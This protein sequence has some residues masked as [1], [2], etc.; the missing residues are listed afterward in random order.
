MVHLT[1]D[2]SNINPRTPPKMLIPYITGIVVQI[3]LKALACIHV[4]F[5]GLGK[6]FVVQSADGQSGS[7]QKS[8]PTE[9]RYQESLMSQSIKERLHNLEA[10]VTDIVGKPTAIPAEK[11]VIL[12]ESLSRIKS[13]EHDLQKTKK[14]V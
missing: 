2:S 11:E 3:L 6:F 4:V 5:T 1:D 14:V 8:E 7:H 13:I 9:S 12:H 10:A